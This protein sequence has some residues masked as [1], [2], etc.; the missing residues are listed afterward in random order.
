MVQGINA[1]AQRHLISK[2]DTSI[3][4]KKTARE[5]PT[6][7]VAK[8]VDLLAGLAL[9]PEADTAEQEGPLVRVA[10]VGVA[11]GELAVVVEH[12][13]LELEPL[14]EEGQL[15]D[16][17]LRLL[18]A[19]AISGQRGNV[20]DDPDVGTG[21]DL[22]VSVDLLLLISPLRQ[23]LGV[24][25][26]GDLAWVVDELEVTRDGLEVL[27][28]LAMLNSDLE[29][30]VVLALS[31]G[32]LNRDSR[33]LLVGGVVGRSDIVREQDL[34]G[35]NV[36]QADQVVVLDDTTQLLVV[37][38]G[39][40]LPVVVGIVVGVTGDLLALARDTAIIVAER[41]SVLVT[42]EV[43]LGLLVANADA[44]VVLDVNS[45][46]QHDVVAEG[47]LE[48]GGHEVVAGAGAVEDG[49]V[50]LEPEEVEQ[51][52]H[53]DQTK[54]SGSKVLGELLEADGAI[55][56][57]DVEQVPEVNDDSRANGD[58][59]EETDVLDRDIAGQSESGQ[60]EPLPPL[61]GE[62]LV[63]ELVPLDVEE[64]TAS[65]GEDEGS[66]QENETGLANVGI[67]KEDET[68]GKNTGGET[69]SGLPHDEV[70]NGNGQ[71]TE[72][73]GQSSEGHVRDLVGNVGV[74]NVLEVEVTIVADQPAHKGEEKLSKGRVD[75][76]EVGSLEVVGSKLRV[77]WLAI[78]R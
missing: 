47:L 36:P 35:T 19:G 29:E 71:S 51:E 53:D 46:G 16:L 10:G 50:D 76:E 14:L 18:T 8:E 12:G 66:I 1:T 48:L 17:A 9:S 75:I 68:G 11:A 77:D 52:G 34:V 21:R 23:R 65:H 44:V 31:V 69:V 78:A 74:A 13:T 25:P 37:V 27:V 57:V 42:V 32:I 22:L 20:L 63:S 26:H 61:P 49:K 41:V 55:G 24:S 62:G 72:D 2:N 5:P 28:L 3:H 64:Q 60:D 15:L 67:V 6:E 59:G 33:E 45:V 58:K 39:K 43:G 7:G 30:S 38:H 40:D 54:G 56:S 4:S 73:G 70:G